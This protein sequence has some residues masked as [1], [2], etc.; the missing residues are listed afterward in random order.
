M[1][2]FEIAPMLYLEEIHNLTKK[3]YHNPDLYPGGDHRRSR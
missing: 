1:F 2:G 3:I